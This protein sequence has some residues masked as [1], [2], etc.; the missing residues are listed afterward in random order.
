VGQREAVVA[1][2]TGR[3]PD[4]DLIV[5][6]AWQHQRLN[7]KEGRVTVVT[8]DD[9]LGPR[10]EGVVQFQDGKSYMVSAR[11]RKDVGFTDGSMIGFRPVG[12]RGSSCLQVGLLRWLVRNV[13]EPGGSLEGLGL[14][15]T[16]TKADAG[17]LLA[18]LDA[19]DGTNGEGGS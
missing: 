15:S 5:T 10:I 12:K 4:A 19:Q 8:P 6:G 9:Y 18:W 16:L 1:I 13:D 14:L 11:P 2:R 7:R 3:P 17:T